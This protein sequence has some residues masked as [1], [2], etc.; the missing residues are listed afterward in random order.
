MHLP[1]MRFRSLPPAFL[2]ALALLIATPLR[3]D[4]RVTDDSGRDVH[5]TQPARRIIS[6]APHITELLFAAGAG[7]RIVGVVAYSNYPAAATR[8]PQVGASNNIDLE[9]I[10]ALKPDLIVAWKS[11]NRDRHLDRLVALGIPIYLNEP[12][13]LDDIG[14]SLQNLG[15]LA[16]TTTDAEAAAAA[17]FARK[18]V[19]Q[20]R[21]GTQ[22]TVRTFYQ[23]WNQPL[24]TINGEHLISKVIAL[25]GGENVFAG[26]SQLVPTLGVEAIL[27]ADPE[28]IVASGMDEARP[29]WLDQW[30]QWP[31]LAATASDNLFFIPPDLIQRPTPRILEG[32]TLLCEQLDNSRR[33][34][35]P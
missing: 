2:A 24:M 32:A 14:R 16:G 26:Q 9:A 6:L 25:C 30:R 33:K 35:H 13:S 7:D 15:R 17:F 1:L 4:I 23:I 27:A 5:V 28:A 31:K 19:L 22:A 12:R 3:A 21:Y 8:L 29:E 18:T 11:G 34:R 20:T 10:A